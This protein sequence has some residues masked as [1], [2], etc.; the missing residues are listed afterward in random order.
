M[1]VATI[2][3]YAAVRK[4]RRVGLFDGQLQE[5]RRAS[6]SGHRRIRSVTHVWRIVGPVAEWP[7]C[8][9]FRNPSPLELPPLAGRLRAGAR[10]RLTHDS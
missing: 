1:Y 10:W 7:G 4:E 2:R 9:A 8:T 5:S 3:T 6:A